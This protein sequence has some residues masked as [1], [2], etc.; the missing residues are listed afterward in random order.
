MATIKS[1]RKRLESLNKEFTGFRPLYQELS[2]YHLAHRGRFLVSDRNKGHKRNT[3][4]INNTSRLAVRTAAS[5]MHAGM[6]SPSRPWFRLSS[7]DDELD[8]ITSVKLWLFQVQTKMYN[9]FSSSNFYNSV[10]SLYSELIV[11]GVAAMG[12]FED[13]DNVIHCQPYTIGSYR[14]ATNGKNVVDTFYREYQITVGQCVK[15]FGMDN[16]SA[17]VQNQ[18]KKGNTEDWVDVVHVIEPNDDRDSASP[19][20]KDKRFRSV[21]FESGTAKGL[22]DKYLLRSGFDDLPIMAPR[23]DVTGEDVYAVDCP[24]MD[25]LGDTK[26]LQLGE[27]KLYQALDKVVDPTLQAPS[28]MRGQLTNGRLPQGEVVFFEGV[29]GGIKSIYD[30]RPDLNAMVSINEKTELRIKR[31]FYEDLFLMLANT[32]RRDIT[33]REIAEKHEEKLLALGPVL[34]RLHTELLNRANTRLFNIL[35]RNGVLP[36][37]PPEL[38]GRDLTIVYISVLAQA[39]RM[40][41]TSSGERLVGFVGQLAATVWPDAAHKIDIDQ[42]IDDYAEAL[43]VNPAAVRSDADVKVI[44]EQQQQQQA[45]AQA[46]AMA[47]ATA[48]VAKTTSQAKTTSDNALGNM[49]GNQP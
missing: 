21:Y 31:A 44:I 19:L 26:A 41:A 37:P 6:T 42:V 9:V 3:K 17:S 15:E 32:D 16:C 40:A 47:Q 49:V 5:G 48:E 39:Q 43:G 7:G 35:Q 2:D 36:P 11:F 23:W 13:F 28:T 14:L 33:A 34:E 22:D 45:M 8:N 29:E 1:Y 18:W 25:A 20:A 10:H 4:Q 27:R 24:G 38:D 30:F 46:M 12:M